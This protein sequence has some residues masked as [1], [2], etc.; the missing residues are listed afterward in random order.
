MPKKVNFES[1]K[2]LVYRIIKENNHLLEFSISQTLDNLKIKYINGEA[3]FEF[4]KK[5]FSLNLKDLRLY[6]RNSDKENL[7]KINY[8]IVF[9]VLKRAGLFKEN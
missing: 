9:I 2:Y 8:N 3:L 6:K 4:Q 1:A 7:D 5:S